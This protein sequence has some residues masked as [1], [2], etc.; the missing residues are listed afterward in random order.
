MQ[1]YVGY[2][3]KKRMSQKK[4]KRKVLRWLLIPVALILIFV[5]L[6]AVARVSP[7]SKWWDKTAD[8]FTWFGRKVKASWPWK[9]T[10]ELKPAKFI[11]EGKKTANYL[12]AFT[13]QMEGGTQLTTLVLASYDSRDD[14]GSLIYL[15]NDLLVNL[16]G[17]GQDLVSNLIEL[18]E[19]RISLTLVMAQNLLGVDID[20]YIMG[21]DRDLSIV[22]GKIQKEYTVD[23][24]GKESFRDPSMNASLNID[25][26]EQEMDPRELAS[27]LTYSEPGKTLDLIKR[28]SGFVPPF[29][30]KSR[31]PDMFKDIVDFMK[32]EA[33][34]FDSDA[35]STE[36]AGLWQSFAL[37]KE[38]KLQQVTVPVKKF[39]FEKTVV[40]TT[41]TE[42]LP[43]FIKKYV[44]TDY[45]KPAGARTRVEILNGNGV[46]GIGQK[47]ASQLDLGAFQ[48]V[49][50]A[51]ADNFDHP[52]TV[53]I[54]YG[55]DKDTVSAAE[56]IKNELEVGR[57]ESHPKNQDIAD[58]TIIVGKDYAS[59]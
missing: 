6:G 1:E 4:K 49:N 51:N 5:I 13:K 55:N 59:K 11:P 46:P 23:V 56:K 24:P 53:I 20:R 12:L 8:G 16:P 32:K 40:H 29:L 22:F 33:N 39:R 7:V 10:A 42:K 25:A 15:P 27:Y 50:S 19:G 45:Q 14:S 28:Q 17:V 34:L 30:E 21:T 37:L 2:R 41:D 38:N 43:G 3:T 48:I 52:E 44:K 26:G 47:V 18:D 35:S 36:I 57:I 31:H 54:I 58:I 9:S